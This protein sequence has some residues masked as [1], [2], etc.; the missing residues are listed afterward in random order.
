MLTSLI[1]D[2]RINELVPTTDWYMVFK[3][4]FSIATPIGD[5]EKFFSKMRIQLG[6]AFHKVILRNCVKKLPCD[7]K[8]NTF[9]S[10]WLR[11]NLIELAVELV[12]YI[13]GLG[14]HQYGFV[15]VSLTY[16]NTK[17]KQWFLSRRWHTLLR[18]QSSFLART[19]LSDWSVFTKCSVSG[20]SW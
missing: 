11:V 15:L 10:R 14:V 9:H 2:Q 3:N 13:W 7:V 12:K 17:T 4:L 18:F 19:L 1:T 6:S 16:S 20:C 5:I 8:S